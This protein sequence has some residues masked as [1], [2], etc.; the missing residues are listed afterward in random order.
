M[1]QALADFQN[2]NYNVA[3]STEP[4]L[5]SIVRNGCSKRL[6]GATAVETCNVYNVNVKS[7]GILKNSASVK[8]PNATYH[9][10]DQSMGSSKGRLGNIE[11]GLESSVR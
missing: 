10:V 9:G 4:E 5:V 3:N 2:V 1:S 7:N 8:H 11:E 6:H